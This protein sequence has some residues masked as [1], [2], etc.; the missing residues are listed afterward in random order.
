MAFPSVKSQHW[1]VLCPSGWDELWG[2]LTAV[3]GFLNES[4]AKELYQRVRALAATHPVIVEIGTFRGRSTIALA[5][6]LLGRSAGRVVTID[7][8][9]YDSLDRSLKQAGVRH[10]VTDWVEESHSARAHFDEPVDLLFIDG[11]HG[12]E[13]ARQDL[14]DWV[15]LIKQGGTLA[16]NDPSWKGVH[17]AIHETVLTDRS[18]ARH[19]TLVGNTLFVVIDRERPWDT[20]D[21]ARLRRIRRLLAVRS[22]VGSRRLH[23]ILPAWMGRMASRVF[24]KLSP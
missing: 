18:I 5:S 2:S 6:A 14:E 9:R 20:A 3:R 24:E 10:L 23:T 13:N 8:N 16:V 19:P 12:Y 7:R 17:R 1:A 22:L 4:E 11:N 15:P 21:A